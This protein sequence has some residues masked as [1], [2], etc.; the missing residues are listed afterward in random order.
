MTCRSSVGCSFCNSTQEDLPLSSLQGIHLTC[1]AYLQM[2]DP[3]LE[4]D[5]GFRQGSPCQLAASELMVPGSFGADGQNLAGP[6]M[7]Y[8][9]PAGHYPPPLYPMHHAALPFGPGHTPAQQFLS[10]GSQLPQRHRQSWGYRG[11]QGYPQQYNQLPNQGFPES[12][13]RSP[14]PMPFQHGLPQH[15]NSTATVNLL[16]T[17]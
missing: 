3:P 12:Y 10:N 9:S 5:P 8:A 11:Q 6:S 1:F 16:F 17:F 14:S 7:T 15:L 13:W 4:M 2:Q